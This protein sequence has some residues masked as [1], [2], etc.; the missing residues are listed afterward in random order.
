MLKTI[1]NYFREK[2]TPS[3]RYLHYS[4]LFLVLLQII[5]SNFIEINDDG[6]IGQN[7]I[8][9]YSTWAHISVGLSL[10]LLAI[11][12]TV[13]EFSKHG[14]SYFYP[15]LSG[16]LS[17]LKSDLSKLKSLE[18][19]DAS[20]KGLAAV[21]QGLGLGAILLVAL[22]GT[23]WFVLRLYDLALA[24][25]VKEIHQLLTGLIEAYIIGH[26]GMGLMHIF[27]AFK[28]QKAANK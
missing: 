17:Q 18:V 2:L 13:V 14:F 15:Y 7:A 20:P 28:E 1:R 3:V 11:V 27:I 21:I 4:I 22:S 5:L 12:F 25:D 26:G 6:A 24:N 10:L 19:P 23:T 9:Y 8:E 16:D